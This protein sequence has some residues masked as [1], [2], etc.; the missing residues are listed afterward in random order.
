[1][2]FLASVL[3]LLTAGLVHAEEAAVSDSTTTKTKM[4]SEVTA[5]R[6]DIDEEITNKKLRTPFF[7]QTVNGRNFI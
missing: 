5:Q 1:M 3:I 6:K 4:P 2:R 7:N